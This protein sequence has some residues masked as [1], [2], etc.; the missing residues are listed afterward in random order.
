REMEKSAPDDPTTLYALG[1]VQLALGQPKDALVT[2]ERLRAKLPNS[3]EAQLRIGQLHEVLGDAKAAEAAYSKAASM[4]RE[5]TGPIVALAKLYARTGRIDDAMKLAED[6]LGRFP[7]LA[8]GNGLMGDLLAG[9]E[10]F[11]QAGLP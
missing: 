9:R 4:G 5:Y 11:A 3:A 10:Q 6:L 8:L 2:Y 1:A 7:K